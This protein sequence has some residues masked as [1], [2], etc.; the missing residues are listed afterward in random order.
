MATVNIDIDQGTVTL[1]GAFPPSDDPRIGSRLHRG[2]G[3]KRGHAEV[4]PGF[5]DR[6]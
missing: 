6:V 3:P 5:P 2:V 4:R 1:R